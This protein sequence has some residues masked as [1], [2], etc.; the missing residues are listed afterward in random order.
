MA[1]KW[2]RFIVIG[3]FVIFLALY[4]SQTSGYYEFDQHQKAALTEEK[5]KQFEKDI[6]S[7]KKIDVDNYL[8]DYYRNYNNNVS[9]SGL[10][11]SK[12]LER[13]F[14][15]IMGVFFKVVERLFIK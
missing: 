3:L 6:K 13:G 1:Y 14:N 15:D 10:K 5:I 4:V 7:G 9:M 2:F 12:T 8:E 11:I